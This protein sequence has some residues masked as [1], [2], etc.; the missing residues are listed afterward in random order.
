VRPGVAWAAAL[1]LSAS[2]AI[3]QNGKVEF[4]RPA[5]RDVT[6][7]GI[8]PGPAVDGPLVRIPTPPRPPEPPRWWRFTL[9]TT[10]DSA[11][12]EKDGKTIRVSGV[13]PPSVDE[14]CPDGNGGDWPCGRTA[15]TNLRKFLHG[16][17]VECYFP[18]VDGAADI[19]A[20]CRVGET[21]IGDWLLAQGWAMPD[22]LATDAYRSA[23]LAARCAG[24]GIWRGG[25]PPQSCP[26]KG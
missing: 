24:R 18:F 13:A 21:D 20:P 26:P 17:A 9:P 2:S 11:T 22:D 12:F 3:A 4:V 19:T 7:P 10:T 15:L 6:P 25:P 16:R 14:I 1:V 8:T 5:D 23:A